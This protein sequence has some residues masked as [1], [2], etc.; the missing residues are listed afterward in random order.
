ML[1]KISKRLIKYRKLIILIWWMLILVIFK[2]YN[3]FVFK[4]GSSII[5]ILLFFVVPLSIM[6][7][8]KRRMSRI[9]AISKIKKTSYFN[10]IKYDIKNGTFHQSF[11]QRLA[12]LKLKV[13]FEDYDDSLTSFDLLIGDND[14]IYLNFT[15][16]KAI[17]QITNTLII[18]RFYYTKAFDELTKYDIRGLE[19]HNTN[20]LYQALY[21]IIE[22][23]VK[24]DLIYEE[25]TLGRKI[26]GY[27]LYR[28][29]E[30]IYQ[31][32]EKKRQVLFKERK[33]QKEINII[34]R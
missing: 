27:Y 15:E 22:N 23:L 8:A 12:R 13:M 16:E 18:Y 34:S 11:L 30:I 19:Y 4:K 31:I 26:I 17:L 25:I 32:K 7:I 21:T 29:G 10:L 28:A 24:D 2:I 1:R 33:S 9:K 14:K 5:F 20:Q 3:N 6:L